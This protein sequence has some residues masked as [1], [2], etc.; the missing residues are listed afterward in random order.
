MS[1]PEKETLRDYTTDLL[2]LETHLLN[3][4]KKQKSSE[5]VRIGEA[6]EL[7]HVLDKTLSVHTTVL[8][9]KVKEMNGERKSKIKSKIGSF[10]GQIAGLVDTVR[11]DPVSKMMRDDYCSLSMI[12]IGYTM[13][14]TLALAANDKELAELSSGN[15]SDIAQLITETSRVVPVVVAL[16]TTDD[17]EKASKIWKE[18]LENTQNAWSAENIADRPEIVSA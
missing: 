12:A 11:E 6:I 4:V 7:L 10:T 3:A 15:L 5:K 8:E 1:K 16:E 17:E 13:L 2:T 9:K 18:A 14:H